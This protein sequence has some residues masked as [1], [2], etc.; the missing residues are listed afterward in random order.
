MGCRNQATAWR[1]NWCNREPADEVELFVLAH[2]DAAKRGRLGP[3]GYNFISRHLV[4]AQYIFARLKNPK[5]LALQ[6]AAGATWQKVGARPDELVSLTTGEYLTLRVA[7]NAYFKAL[8][9]IEAGT[10]RQACNVAER[11]MEMSL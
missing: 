2:F 4:Q 9:R 10:Y 11:A 5:L 8:P 6:Q 1:L 7:L 3:I